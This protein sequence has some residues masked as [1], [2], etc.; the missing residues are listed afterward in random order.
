MSLLKT[1]LP[2]KKE[3]GA[4]QL[5]GRK[6]QY[7]KE[8]REKGIIYIVTKNPKPNLAVKEETGSPRAE[9]ENP[10]THKEH[11]ETNIIY[12]I[13]KHRKTNLAAK[14][15]TGSLA[16]RRMKNTKTLKKGR[17]TVKFL[18]LLKPRDH[19]NQTWP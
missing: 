9:I 2:W 13:A 3:T 7:H 6:T 17:E 15:E 18:S 14:E 16:A 1:N 8:H 19:Q 5:R 4:H 11:R 10:Q 12:I